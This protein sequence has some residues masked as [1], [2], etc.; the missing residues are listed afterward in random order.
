M[1]GE[2]A[3]HHLVEEVAAL[4]EWIDAQLRRHSDRAA[5]CNACG[6]CCDFAAYDHRL[7]VTP[8]ELLYLA[9][10]LNTKT[11]K[12]NQGTRCPYQEDD[13]CTI[14]AHRFAGCRIFCCNGDP[15]FQSELSE[16]T[17]K[18]LKATC[19]R[20]GLPYH[21]RELHEALRRFST[22]TCRSAEAP[23]PA[24]REDLCTSRP[25]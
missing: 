11:L 14:H 9:S 15:A 10:R 23:C 19:E 21:Y 8:P 16:V 25:R 1:V 4:Y 3:R 22:D 7:F 24:D 17:L 20:F 6:A 5:R 12:S 2:S 18:K 13:R